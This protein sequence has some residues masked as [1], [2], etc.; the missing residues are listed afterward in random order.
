MEAAYEYRKL[1]DTGKENWKL[2]TFLPLKVPNYNTLLYL[3]RYY[4]Y[5]SIGM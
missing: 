5:M 1:V 3:S 2:I 4:I